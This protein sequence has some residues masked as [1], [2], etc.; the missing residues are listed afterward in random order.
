MAWEGEVGYLSWPVGRGTYLARGGVPTLTGGEG[1]LPWRG[2]YLPWPGGYLPWLGTYL[3][4]YPPS[5][6]M[7]YL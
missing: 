7:G 1:Y 5:T 4:G 3:A 2:A 6:E